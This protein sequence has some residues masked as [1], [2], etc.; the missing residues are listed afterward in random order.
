MKAEVLALIVLIF[1]PPVCWGQAPPQK[2]PPGTAP[3]TEL[4]A[5]QPTPQAPGQVQQGEVRTDV[6]GRPMFTDIIRADYWNRVLSFWPQLDYATA[7]GFH[8]AAMVKEEY[9]SNLHLSDQDRLD[10][11][12]TTLSPGLRYLKQNGR[13]GVDLTYIPGYNIYAKNS[14]LNYWSHY[15]TLNSHYNLS[16]RWTFR[17]RDLLIRSDDPLEYDPLGPVDQYF[18]S[19]S[20]QRAPHLRNIAEP[21]IEYRFGPDSFA[22]LLYRNMYYRTKE[23]DISDSMENTINPRVMYWFNIHNGVLLDYSYTKA[24]FS[25]SPDWSGNDARARYIYR[26][27]PGTSFFGEYYYAN[28]AFDPPSVSYRVHSP[29]AGVEHAFSPTLNAVLQVGYYVKQPELGESESSFSGNLYLRKKTELTTYNLT[30][31]WGFREE[32]LTPENLGFVEYRRAEV[33]IIRALSPRT[34]FSIIGMAENADYV[35]DRRDWI[36]GAQA[37][38]SWNAYK[39]LTVNPLVWYRE[40][41]SN[42]E[43]FDYR[44]FRG[45]LRLTATY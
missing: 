16:P 44:E 3:G 29:S 40:R 2:Q 26:V 18:L 45:I 14:D 11:F 35:T 21:Q 10:D 31:I 39:W 43:T 24:G 42:T 27:N 13:A 4:A 19:T 15:G 20:T 25:T 5:P 32:Y 33:N 30:L 28:R 12:I 7:E 6:F 23:G 8:L 1:L 17:L 38:F 9:S 41:N 36:Y 22:G 37:A 34:S